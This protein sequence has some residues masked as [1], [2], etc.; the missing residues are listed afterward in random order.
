MC[1]KRTTQKF[2]ALS[3]TAG[4][5][6][7]ACTSG[8]KQSIEHPT[9]TTFAGNEIP[10]LYY[11]AGRLIVDQA[12]RDKNLE[13]ATEHGTPYRHFTAH[14]LAK[15]TIAT[16]REL[17]SVDV[18]KYKYCKGTFDGF[19]LTKGEPIN[20]D[21]QDFSVE[22]KAGEEIPKLNTPKG[23]KLVMSGDFLDDTPDGPFAR[24]KLELYETSKGFIQYSSLEVNNAQPEMEFVEIDVQDGLQITRVSLSPGLIS[25]TNATF[26]II[27]SDTCQV[28]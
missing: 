6:L 14:K 20:I 16:M 23:A 1:M 27:S 2:A 7:G 18:D 11:P 21:L 17:K 8:N 24:T 25:G 19:K 28:S 5:F 10:N 26:P 4:M 12:F 13:Y 15:A 3:L 22:T 9:R